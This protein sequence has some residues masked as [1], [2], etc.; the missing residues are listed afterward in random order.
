M[1]QADYTQIATTPTTSPP[2][3]FKCPSC[4]Q[5]VLDNRPAHNDDSRQPAWKCGN[6]A[7]GGGGEK[8]DGSGNWPWATWETDYFAPTREG[9]DDGDLTVSG[10]TMPVPPVTGGF[11]VPASPESADV[12]DELLRAL[13]EGA[14]LGTRPDIEARTRE[15]CRLMEANGLWPA[16]S[17]E[18]MLHLKGWA[19]TPVW[20]F[21]LG[22]KPQMAAFAQK[23]QDKANAK[24]T[25]AMRAAVPP[26][27]ST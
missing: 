11:D 2:S 26:L 14:G 15:L 27:P 9:D 6:R 4:E 10:A 12:W 13:S 19:E 17:L 16:D 3:G 25:E 22:Q 24:V 20:P 21:P 18:T 23:V 7:C 1:A 8:K 5:P